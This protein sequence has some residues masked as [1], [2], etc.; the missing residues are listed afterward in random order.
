MR[1]LVRGEEALSRCWTS[2]CKRIARRENASIMHHPAWVAAARRLKFYKR[3]SLRR[4]S[5][6]VEFRLGSCFI[7]VAQT[8]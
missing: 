1:E 7:E 6:F 3:K 8:L 2:A 4:L 5:F